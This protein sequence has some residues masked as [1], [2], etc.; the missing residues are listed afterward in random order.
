MRIVEITCLATAMLSG[1]IIVGELPKG[2]WSDTG[3]IG[4]ESDTGIA[5][6][7][8]SVSPSELTLGQHGEFVISADPVIEYELVS[9]VV[10]LNGAEV[11]RFTVVDDGITA[12]I[13]APQHAEPGPITL[14][15]EY[16]DGSAELIPKAFELVHPVPDGPSEGDTGEAQDEQPE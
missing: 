3:A 15:L 6:T 9:E 11:L 5:Q 7:E 14:V 2:T 4:I 8:F 10:A 1:C 12:L 16:T 13:A